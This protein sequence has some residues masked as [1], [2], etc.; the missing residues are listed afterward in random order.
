MVRVHV[1]LVDEAA[2]A[3]R[4][5]AV[6]GAFGLASPVCLALM[7]CR[8]FLLLEALR[9]F[10]FHIAVAVN[11][12]HCYFFKGG[13]RYLLQKKARSWCTSLQIQRGLNTS[14]LFYRVIF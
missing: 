14:H 13:G 5:R 4:R 8:H 3:W 2:V 11:G 10:P 12:P 7:R 6:E 1:E 9:A